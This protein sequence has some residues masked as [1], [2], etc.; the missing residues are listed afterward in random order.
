MISLDYKGFYWEQFDE[1]QKPV[2]PKECHVIFSPK[3]GGRLVYFLNPD[4]DFSYDEIKDKRIKV[5][6]GQA[7]GGKN[8]TF[9]NLKFESARPHFTANL[10]LTEVVF[11]IEYIFYDG[12]VDIDKKLQ[13]MH[14]RYSYLELWFNQLE[15]KNPH[16]DTNKTFAGI[17]VH[18]EHLK[19][20]SSEYDVLF[21]IDN[22]FNQSSFNNKTVTYE[23]TNSLAIAK[24]EDFNIEEAISLSLLVKN[25]FEVITFYSKNKIFIEEFYIT[26]KRKLKDGY[27]VDEIVYLLFKQDEY[28][29]EQKMTHLDFLFRYDDVK[30]NFVAILNNWIKNHDKNQ[31][32]YQAFC[33]VIADK[34]SKFNIYSHYFQLISA[35][36]AYH[37]LQHKDIEEQEEQNHKIYLESLKTKLKTCLTSDEKKKILYKLKYQYGTSFKERLKNLIEVSQIKEVIVCEESIHNEITE[38]IYKMR[39]QVA[40]LKNEIELNK[41]LKSSFEYLKLVALLIMLKEISL[42]HAQ[43]SKNIFDMD[44]KFVRNQLIEAFQKDCDF[45]KLND[46]E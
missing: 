19:G 22:G 33:N 17:A 10:E 39:N 45:S 37:R 32:E 41:Q 24:K 12:F 16:N 27:E 18:K 25:F 6:Y 28:I 11:S 38:F 23:A 15:I 36:E 3:D 31:N 7:S 44:I 43:I 14:V 1:F 35:L 5:L 29:E 42:N 8:F 13:I 2:N 30:E 26:Q 4:E 9:C 21:N 20:S 40:H 34:T 46:K